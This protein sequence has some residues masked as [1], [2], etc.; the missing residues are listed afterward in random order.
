MLLDVIEIEMRIVGRRLDAMLT[1][2][3]AI[4]I[5]GGAE[6]LAGGGSNG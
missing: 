4:R 6:A 3:F 2:G 1:H 5:R